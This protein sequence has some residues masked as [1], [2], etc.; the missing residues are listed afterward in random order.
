MEDNN[1]YSMV[2]IGIGVV[3]VIIIFVV[4]FV[5]VK[6]SKKGSDSKPL[7]SGPTPAPISSSTPIAG[8]NA[9]VPSTTPPAVSAQASV[10]HCSPLSNDPNSF[11]CESYTD[12]TLVTSNIIQ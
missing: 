2:G 11:I 5:V 9:A 4:V 3:I 6:P 10:P 1:M 7:V 8:N 12:G